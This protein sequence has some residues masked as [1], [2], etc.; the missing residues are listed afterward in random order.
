MTSLRVEDHGHVRV[1]LLARPERRNAIDQALA[2]EL[3]AAFDQLEGERSVRAVVLT[4]DGGYFSAG[5]DLTSTAP[6]RT[7]GGAYGFLARVRRKPLT[8]AVEGFALGGG[9]ECVLACDLVVASR[10]ARFGLPEV[11][12]GLVA[13]SGALFRAPARLPLSLATEL[14]LTG[15][16]IPA[17]R[18][19]QHGLINVLSAPG[20]ALPE[21]LR[22]ADRIAV[23]SPD[24]VQGSLR[25]IHV[26]AAEREIYGWEL[27]RA[28]D[29]ENASSPDRVEGVRAFFEKRPPR[30]S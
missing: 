8:A 17:E 29:E 30:W 26:E 11:K 21:A 14:L 13:N 19:Y 20:E 24:A 5:T 12:R 7:E 10:E 2:D 4:G 23:N 28:A 9:F 16:P 27:T 25:A 22:L 1:L 15:D 6:P 3:S 18:A